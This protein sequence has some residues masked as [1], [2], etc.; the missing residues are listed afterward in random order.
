MCSIDGRRA[1]RFD[2]GAARPVTDANRSNAQS[3][4]EEHRGE[5]EGGRSSQSNETREGAESTSVSGLEVFGFG[6]AGL[7]CGLGL[8]DCPSLWRGHWL[9]SL[10]Q[11]RGSTQVESGASQVAV[12]L[13]SSGGKVKG[14]R[15][16]VETMAKEEREEERATDLFW[17]G[18]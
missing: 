18:L 1:S 7:C 17:V 8:G 5:G 3:N 4:R 16:K 14:E 15:S 6:L 10:G 2:R 12:H 9:A 11:R 13:K